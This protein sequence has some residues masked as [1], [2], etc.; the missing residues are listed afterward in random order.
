M[1]KALSIPLQISFGTTVFCLS[2]SPILAQVTSDGTVNTQV[3]QN[4]SVAEITGG[5][6]RGSNLFHSFQDF[7]VE[8]GNEA[9]FNN[10]DNISN[11][12][13]RV[14]GGNI[15]NID[16]LIRA[17]D[18]ASL[19]L[20]NP[21][22]IVFGENARLDIGGSFYGS[23]ASSILFEDGEFSAADLDNPPLLTVN[24]PI[25]LSFR[26]NPASI[27]VNSTASVDF[28]PMPSFDDDLFG[29]RVPD[30]ETFALAGGDI[31]ADGGGIVVSRWQN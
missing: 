17:N 4:G 28:E 21:N 7:S 25:G 1:S 13:S 18:S 8:T 20:I 14:T 9:F 5:E 24:A 10:A 31:T 15:S 30:G 26:D 16:G 19:F 6:T 11:I 3:E 12:F 22:G 29:L 27:E 23:S 2:A